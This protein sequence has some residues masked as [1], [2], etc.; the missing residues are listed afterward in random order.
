MNIW[1]ML[2]ILPTDDIAK[3]KAAYA[4]KAKEYHPEEHPEEFKALQ[5]AYKTAV[6]LAKQKKTEQP[7]PQNMAPDGNNLRRDAERVQ[8]GR[9]NAQEKGQTGQG[10]EKANVRKRQDADQTNVQKRQDA[11]QTEYE[12][13]M[14]DYSGIDTYG[15][16]E[17]FFRQ[18]L[19]LAK[20]PFLQ[21]N[22]NVWK[23][24]LQQ[25]VFAKFFEEEAFCHRFVETVCSLHGWSWKTIRF[26]EAWMRHFHL[27]EAD[28]SLEK[29]KSCFALKGLLSVP[30]PLFRKLLLTQ[31]ERGMHETVLTLMRKRKQEPDLRNVQDIAVYIR[32]YFSYAYSREKQIDTA[33]RKRNRRVRIVSG[34][35][36]AFAVLIGACFYTGRTHAEQTRQQWKAETVS[37]LQALLEQGMRQEQEPEDQTV[38]RAVNYEKRQEPYKEG[39]GLIFPDDVQEDMAALWQ[40][41]MKYRDD[42]DGSPHE[43]SVSNAK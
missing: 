38:R 43:N 22:R 5:K 23:L 2:G 18:F 11:D 40:S 10:T 30:V 34:M 12:T 42:I 3:I 1:E 37:G 13:E 35:A 20:N 31:S 14:F 28:G 36:A 29:G 9:N 27:E 17:L 21:N 7:A 16:R 24:F 19:L 41:Y 39:A 6:W 8:A 4:A 26:F 32:T 33:Y 25:P 15:D